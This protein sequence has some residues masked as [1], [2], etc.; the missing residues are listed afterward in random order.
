M[1]TTGTLTKPVRNTGKLRT[2]PYNAG[3]V[4]T[5]VYKTSQTYG[6]SY[7]G[8]GARQESLFINELRSYNMLMD[9]RYACNINVVFKNFKK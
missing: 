1:Y 3:I 6:H 5:Y 2:K 4:F 9:S 7:Y 8:R